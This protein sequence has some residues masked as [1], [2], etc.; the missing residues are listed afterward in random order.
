[1]FSA[2]SSSGADDNHR[3]PDKGKA[4]MTEEEIAAEEEEIAAAMRNMA[5]EELL[6]REGLFILPWDNTFPK[7]VRIQ[8]LEYASMDEAKIFLQLTLIKQ[9]QSSPLKLEILQR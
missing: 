9:I 3:D 8:S 2:G 5:R 1:M 6:E 7:E 4:P